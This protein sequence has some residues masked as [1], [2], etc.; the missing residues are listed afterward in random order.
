MKHH[1]ITTVTSTITS[2][3]IIDIPSPS[4]RPSRSTIH[5]EYF[6]SVS[7]SFVLF[8][9]PFLFISYFRIVMSLY[10]YH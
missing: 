9:Y 2:I 8:S 4:Y 7:F 1:H 10:G 6:R 3:I 5:S